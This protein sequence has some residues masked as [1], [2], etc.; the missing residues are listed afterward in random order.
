MEEQN[1]KT[2]RPRPHRNHANT[3]CVV[4]TQLR[5]LFPASGTLSRRVSGFSAPS[6]LE[7]FL[8]RSARVLC[9]HVDENICRGEAV[10]EEFQKQQLYTMWGRSVPM[11]EFL[12]SYVLINTKGAFWLAELSTMWPPHRGSGGV[13]V[14]YGLGG[15]QESDC[16]GFGSLRRVCL[17]WVTPVLLDRLMSSCR[18]KTVRSR[19][20][21][22]LETQP[23]WR[24]SR[25]PQNKDEIPPRGCQNVS[26]EKQGDSGRQKL[27]VWILTPIIRFV[28]LKTKT[29]EDTDG[30]LMDIKQR[31][32]MQMETCSE[33][34]SVK[35]ITEMEIC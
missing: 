1:L 25:S 3:Q 22:T 4:S 2:S 11:R 5:V 21:G 10:F 12:V 7:E 29:D 19:T 20:L 27:L 13:C 16:V 17:F 18:T 6:G 33:K 28:F 31:Q 9:F 34:H 30:D 24:R 15:L 35:T 23:A 32:E 14:C 8:Q 26:W